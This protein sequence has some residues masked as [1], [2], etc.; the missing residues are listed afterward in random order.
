MSRAIT[1]AQRAM[2]LAYLFSVVL[3][4]IIIGVG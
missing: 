3:L 4:P 1:I 2:I